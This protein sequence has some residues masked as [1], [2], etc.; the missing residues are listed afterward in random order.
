MIHRRTGLAV[1]AALALPL[2]PTFADA[3][4]PLPLGSTSHASLPAEDNALFTFEA[5]MAG[6]LTVVVRADGDEDLSLAVSDDEGQPL[7]GGGADMD[8]G[9]NVGAEQLVVTI[10]APGRYTVRVRSLSS[11]GGRFQIGGSFM[12]SALA[13]GV[14]DPD[15]RPSGATQLAVGT[16]HEDALDPSGGDPW[17]WYR[18]PVTQDGVLT[19]LTRA[20]GD[21]DLRLERFADGEFG[22]AMDASDQDM[23]G[24]LGNESLTVNVRA[25]DVVFLRVTSAFGGGGYAP[26]R[27]ASGLIPG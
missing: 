1:L 11:S 22:E 25:G 9:G 12:A 10:P 17:D 19:V 3:Q 20:E 7:P 23:D 5:G 16:S 21:G 15:G 2:F 13:G 8:L 26:Y 24:V 14:L 6:F 27:I 4:A 18:I